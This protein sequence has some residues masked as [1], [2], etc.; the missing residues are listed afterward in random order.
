[1]ERG[2]PLSV[3]Q[4]LMLRYGDLWKVESQVSIKLLD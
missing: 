4:R 2:L 1:M 3:D